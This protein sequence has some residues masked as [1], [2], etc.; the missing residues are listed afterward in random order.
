MHIL[1]VAPCPRIP[2]SSLSSP[3]VCGDATILFPLLISQTFARHWQPREEPPQP[4]AKQ[5]NGD[6]AANGTFK[7]TFD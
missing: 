6:A 5:A 4:A 3:Q 7:A 2:P 1:Y